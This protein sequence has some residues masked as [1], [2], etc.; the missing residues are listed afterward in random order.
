MERIN[1]GYYLTL[2]E[3]LQS[4]VD[5]VTVTPLG[6]SAGVAKLLADLYPNNRVT[7]SLPRW[8]SIS[9]EI[10]G[11]L[12]APDIV[13][14]LRRSTKVKKAPLFFEPY[15]PVVVTVGTNI[16]GVIWES[17]AYARDTDG[18]KFVIG[19]LE[20]AASDPV[21]YF[22]EIGRRWGH[23]ILCRR[24]LTAEKSLEKSIGPVCYRTVKF[25]QT[26]AQKN[27]ITQ[28]EPVGNGECPIELPSIVPSVPS[29]TALDISLLNPIEQAGLH[30]FNQKILTLT[31]LGMTNRAD[32]TL[33]MN[34]P[35]KLTAKLLT[36]GG[37][38]YLTVLNDPDDTRAVV[39]PVDAHYD[40][41]TGDWIVQN[42]IENTRYINEHFTIVGPKSKTLADVVRV[43]N[44]SST[45][46]IY[47]VPFG[48]KNIIKAIQGARWN[49]KIKAWTVPSSQRA[50]LD[51]A[52]RTVV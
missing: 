33:T 22:S 38:I 23:C 12:P 3:R 26:E 2:D 31:S 51:D 18:M 1:P 25:L 28:G 27:P 35:Q 10:H 20:Y 13:Y 30:S 21:T 34:Y 9:G 16:I 32:G 29:L 40:A 47:D 41:T 46:E 8:T 36:E 19:E 50:A 6:L 44:G 39:E 15:D 4:T 11:P 14:V 52:L 7:L 24:E 48:Q 49:P 42:T 5:P 37:T 45:I 17:T 43:I